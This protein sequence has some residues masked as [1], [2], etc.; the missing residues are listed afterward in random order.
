MLIRLA[1]ELDT[2]IDFLLTGRE[3]AGLSLVVEELRALL[4]RAEAI[5]RGATPA[6]PSFRPVDPSLVQPA[7]LQ[8]DAAT[9]S[10]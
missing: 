8:D 6:Q 5:Q 3:P 9:G 7:V 2:S 1:R 4:L 10:K